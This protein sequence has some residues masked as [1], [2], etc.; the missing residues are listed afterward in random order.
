MTPDPHDRAVCRT[1]ST[2]GPIEDLSSHFER[3]DLQVDPSG[4]LDTAGIP[5]TA[6]MVAPMDRRAVKRVHR[7]VRRQEHQIHFGPR[8]DAYAL[9]SSGGPFPLEPTVHSFGLVCGPA[10]RRDTST[11][12]RHGMGGSSPRGPGRRGFQAR[13]SVPSDPQAEALGARFRLLAARWKRETSKLSSAVRMAAHPAY[14]EIIG[15]GERA[16]PLILREM[17]QHGPGHWFVALSL[18]TG[19]NPVAADMAGDMGRMTE[20][21]IAWGTKRG[22]LGA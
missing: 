17:K 6:T 20:A 19:A 15:M 5:G 8:C 16:V 22:Y 2:A 4:D 7:A 11:R 18:L 14:W 21:W 3:R 10:D 1:P 9:F 12:T 13:E